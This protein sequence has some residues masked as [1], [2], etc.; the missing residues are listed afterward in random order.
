MAAGA[1][2]TP[3]HAAPRAAPLAAA[4]PPVTTEL[5]RTAEGV[6][7]VGGSAAL[8]KMVRT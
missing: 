6:A 1:L 2:A 4:E 5:E 7:Q 3:E 8:S